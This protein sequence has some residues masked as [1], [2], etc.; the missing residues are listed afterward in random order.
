MQLRSV[1]SAGMKIC[2]AVLDTISFTLK[3][4]QQIHELTFWG[5]GFQQCYSEFVL[6]TLC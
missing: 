2:Q 6:N 3:E 1:Y 5:E 4:Q